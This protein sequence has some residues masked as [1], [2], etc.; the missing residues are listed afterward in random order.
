MGDMGNPNLDNVQNF[1]DVG[2]TI[3]TQ[4]GKRLVREGVLF[5]SARPDDASPEDRR[6]LK[7]DY[8]IKT[9]IDL[10]TKT[11]HAKQAEKRQAD[12][13]VPALLKSNAALAEPVQ[14]PGL[15]YLEI[16]ITGGKFEKF[17]IS[18]LSWP[19][20]FKLIFLYTCGYRIAAIRVMS[21]EVMLPRGLV[22]MGLDTLDHSGADILEALDAFLEPPADSN[23]GASLPILVHCTQGKDRTGLIVA[24]VLMILGVPLEAVSHDYLLTQEALV[25]DREA[26][27]AEI[28]EIGLTPDWGDCPPDFVARVHEHLVSRYGGIEAYLD[29]IEF[30][31]DKRRRLVEVLGA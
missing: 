21:Q 25:E 7:E 18:Q 8:G 10:R 16:K 1:R 6:K 13:K 27:I 31:S 28:E 4:C 24:L 2:Q 30:G 17:L 3:N 29:D 22:T 23:G 20:F 5:R 19:G 9:V 14:I 15:R 11:E 26:R 12:L